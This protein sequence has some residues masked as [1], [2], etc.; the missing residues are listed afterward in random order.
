[1]RIIKSVSVM[2]KYILGLKSKNKRIGFVPTM[3]YLHK[4]HGA[5]LRRCRKENNISV[6]SIFVNPKQFGPNEDF[7][8][9]PRD[10]KKDELFAQREK[11]D[12]IFYP[13]ADDM[14]PKDYLTYV[15]VGKIAQGLCGKFRPG[16]FRGVATVVGKLINV[17][18]PDIL[19]LGQKDAQQA[20]ILKRMI[21]DLNFP[22][23]VKIVPTVREQDGLAMSSRNSYLNDKQRQQAPILYRTLR[24]A[25]GLIQQGQR[26]PRKIIGQMRA[27]ILKAAPFKIDYIEC[28]DA[29]SL[30]PLKVLRGD[31]L[32]A[33][34]AWL[35]KTRLID[36]IVLTVK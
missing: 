1:M 15:E 24:H 11:V 14:Y 22:V 17:I 3:G 20:A 26:N 12:I 29:A 34:A 30:D 28:V 19:Y 16:H 10:L 2:Q 21:V 35:G 4:G 23:R 18:Q 25:E 8:R 33:L 13:S 9:Y 6:L 27:M 7:H 32:I 36:N 31:I 5:L